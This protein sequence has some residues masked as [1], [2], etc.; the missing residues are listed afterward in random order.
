MGS[1][2]KL[3]SL[4]PGKLGR[5]AGIIAVSAA[6][7]GLASCSLDYVVGFVYVTTTKSSPGAINQYAIDFQSGAL[8]TIG[9]PVKAG[10][11]PVRIIAA[12][13]GKFV[14]V[15]NQGDST[16]QEFAV[17][18]DGTLTSKNT[19][20][21]SG[22]TSPTALTIDPGGKFLYATFTYQTGFSASNPGPGGVAIFPINSD[23]TLGTQTTQPVGNNPIAVTASYFN[24]YIYVLDQ[25]PSPKATIL[26]FAQNTTTGALTPTPGTNIGT[27]GGK[28]VAT[29]YPAGVAPS[30]IAEEP[31]S[32]FVYVT[33]ELANQLIGYT[34]GSTG[35]LT[36]M[37]NGPFPTGLYPANLTIDPTGTL[38]YV[39][40]FNANTVQGYQINE[41]TGTPAT[42]AGAVGSI[43][44]AG[45]NCVV[46][47]PALGNFL[48]TSDQLDNTA[49]AFKVTVNDG[50][51][52]R[53]QNTPFP[54][55]GS[56][57]C[58]T[59]VPNGPHSTQIIQP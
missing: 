52:A 54:T 56:P 1:N 27:S 33:D 57:S 17:N 13:N 20:N 18:T 5:L 31:T 2:M 28:T 4:H 26:G 22:G 15:A 23:N 8:T 53:V 30:A 42:V 14:Y 39:V 40:N 11:N 50:T 24:H 46:I 38:I 44:G 48:Y 10:N 35:A 47:D 6:V 16:V 12:P 45:P 58:L 21:L 32:R 59:S 36:P 41:T 51:L 25:E 34:V 43:T 19:Y 49:S 29:G 7:L 3:E 9:T 55:G 37:V